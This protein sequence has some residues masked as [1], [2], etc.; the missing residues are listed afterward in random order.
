M[1]PFNDFEDNDIQ[2][3]KHVHTDEYRPYLVGDY[4]KYR[5]E[6]YNP[7]ALSGYRFQS[8][9]KKIK[10]FSNEFSFTLCAMSYFRKYRRYLRMVAQNDSRAAVGSFYQDFTQSDF[11]RLRYCLERLKAEA[12]N[13]PV[14]VVTV[15]VTQDFTG[16]NAGNVPPLLVQRLTNLATELGFTYIDLMQAFLNQAQ[17]TESLYLPCDGHWNGQGQQLAANIILDRLKKLYPNLAQ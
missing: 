5:I 11:L 16:T 13:K 12:G 3:A 14:C 6:Y 9:R 4:P 10:S 15:P 7:A 1:L 17:N 2:K 8:I